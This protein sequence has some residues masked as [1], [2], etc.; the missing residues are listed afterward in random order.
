[1]PKL[2]FLIPCYNEEDGIPKLLEALGETRRAVGPAYDWELVFVDDGSSDR[3]EAM[4]RS[5]AAS[6]PAIRVVRHPRNRGLGAALRTGFEAVTG[7]LVATADSDCTYDPREIV[8][9]L[10]LLTPDVDVVIGSPYHPQGRV[11][12]VPAYRL[13]LSRNLSRIYGWVIGADLYTYTSLLRLYRSKVVKT[14]TFDSNDFLAMAQIVVAARLAGFRIVEYPT[15]LRVRR[16][17]SSKAIIVRLI[18][19]HL[20][21]VFRLVFGRARGR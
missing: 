3:T 7:D 11:E 13:V 4:L 2:S 15:T 9:M 18:R 8:N 21:F 12:N 17:G 5:A 6:D 20:G 14:V 16:A 10:K 1:M 19:D